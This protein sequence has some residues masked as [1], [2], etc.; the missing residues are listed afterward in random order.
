VDC[1]VGCSSREHTLEGRMRGGGLCPRFLTERMGSTDILGLI[2]SALQ[3]DIHK[4]G[5][6]NTTMSLMSPRCRRSSLSNRDRKY[7]QGQP[8]HL[9]I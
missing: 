1:G 4:N 9:K 3:T 8:K 6:G 7:A 5:V 2:R